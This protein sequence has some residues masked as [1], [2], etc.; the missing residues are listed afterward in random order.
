MARESP[1]SSRSRLRFSA[2]LA[3]LVVRLQLLLCQSAP[4]VAIKRKRI[5][6]GGSTPHRLNQGLVILTDRCEEPSLAYSKLCF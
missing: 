4:F 2:I 1:P 3:A 6:A 5:L